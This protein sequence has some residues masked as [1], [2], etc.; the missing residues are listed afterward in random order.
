MWQEALFAASQI[1]FSAEELDVL[2]S[3]LAE[4]LYEAK[5]YLE[6]ATIHLDYR[7]D[8]AEAARILCKGCYFGEAMRVVCIGHNFSGISANIR[9]DWETGKT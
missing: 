2:S 6:A 4:T 3:E 5:D 1:P 8:I 7:D 9:I